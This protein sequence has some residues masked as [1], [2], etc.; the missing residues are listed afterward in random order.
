MTN[1]RQKGARGEREWAQYLTGKGFPARRGQQFRGGSDSADVI[2]ERLDDA[3][4]WEVKR[5]EA[6]NINDA[7]EQAVRD[8]D[9]KIGIVAHRKNG[10]EWKVTLLAEHFFAL[11]ESLGVC[12]QKTLPTKLATQ[13]ERTDC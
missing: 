10:D 6:L 11:L 2:C 9:G 13:K 3:F 12:G 7:V 5:V 4:Q 1:S 8:A